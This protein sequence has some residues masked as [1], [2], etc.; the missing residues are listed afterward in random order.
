M[1]YANP[2]LGIGGFVNVALPLGS[3][4]IAANGT[5]KVPTAIT[6]GAI[7]GKSVGQIVTNAFADYEYNTEDGAKY[8]QDAIEAYAQGQYNITPLVGPYLGVDFTKTLNGE[9]DG[10]G[11]SPSTA[12]HLLTLKPGANFAINDKF[13]VELNVP[14]TVLGANAPDYWGVYVGA[15]YTFSL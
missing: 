3:K 10:T 15:Y 7:Y 2:D 13:A 4:K 5:S 12:G 14:V 11:D 9:T 1:K 6:V 8:K